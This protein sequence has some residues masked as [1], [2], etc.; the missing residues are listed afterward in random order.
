MQR[1]PRK[2]RLVALSTDCIFSLFHQSAYS[3]E[4][5]RGTEDLKTLM[6]HSLAASQMGCE[7]RDES[8]MLLV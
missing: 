3:D 8:E 4:G 2:S 1:K 7:E 6:K 5:K